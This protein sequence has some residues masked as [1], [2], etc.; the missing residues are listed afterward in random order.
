[1]L[2]VD[3]KNEITLHCLHNVHHPSSSLCF[4][5]LVFAPS[6]PNFSKEQWISP[7]LHFVTSH[8]F[9][10][11]QCDFQNP[12]L[13][14]KERQ[15]QTPNQGAG[16]RALVT[17]CPLLAQKSQRD[18]LER[19]LRSRSW[20]CGCAAGGNG[21]ACD[22]YARQSPHHTSDLECSPLAQTQL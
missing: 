8:L 15:D 2:Y 16:G 21:C 7:C 17:K 6:L 18:E 20:H 19:K 1:M 5:A 11:L 13:P 22:I 12:T 10:S 4:F 9:S 3:S 14:F